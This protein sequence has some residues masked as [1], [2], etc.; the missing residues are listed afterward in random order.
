MCKFLPAFPK[1][2]K[3][4]LL[5]RYRSRC[6]WAPTTYIG[7]NISIRK[8]TNKSLARIFANILPEFRSN[9]CPNS[10]RILP[11]YRPNL[12]PNEIYWPLF[13]L[14]GGGVPP[15]P[16]LI[17]LCMTQCLKVSMVKIPVDRRGIRGWQGGGAIAPLWFWPFASPLSKHPGAALARRC[18][19]GVRLRTPYYLSW[20]SE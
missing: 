2:G 10:T 20:E 16:C 6:T 4:I 14:G 15:V 13:F 19:K 3:C 12:H 11:E 8:Q 1:D 9:L 18:E 5:Y 7:Q 17:R